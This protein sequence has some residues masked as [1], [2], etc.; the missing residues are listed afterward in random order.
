MYF[1]NVVWKFAKYISSLRF[2]ISLFLLLASVSVLGTIIEQDQTL[3]YYRLNYPDNK[4]FLFFV[5]WKTI[6]FSGLNHLYSTY[7]FCS[8]LFLFF[9]SLLLCTFS[10]QLPI[11][12]QARQWKFLYSKEFLAQKKLYSQSKSSSLMNFVYLL[13]F[14]YYYTFH[15]G[16][17]VYAYK[18]LLGRIAPI[19]VHMSIIITLVGSVLGA[20]G[21]FVVQEMIPNGEIFHVQNIVKAGYLSL[22]PPDF[23]GKV[24]DFFVTF[25]DDLSVQQFFS[26]ILLLDNNGRTLCDKSVS[27]NFP[28]RFNGLTFY[29]TDWQVNALRFQV[30]SDKY[31]VKSLQKVKIDNKITSFVWFCDLMLD[32]KHEIFIVV[33]DLSNSLLI[34]DHDR[35]LVT[36]TQY[37]VWN[38][39]YGVPIVFKDLMVSTGLQI[40][41]DPGL[42]ISY[43][44]FLILIVSIIVSYISYSQIWMSKQ[45]KILSLSGTTNRAFIFFEREFIRIYKKYTYLSGCGF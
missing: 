39:V 32:K 27:V 13:N 23:V 36:T 1:K 2:S 17:A 21:G 7:W 4:P 29:Q 5:T 42:Y 38:I 20:T 10:T 11:L 26:N 31:L 15:K 6:M 40:K 45:D 37:G 30:G 44:G 19:F 16:K 28:L 34:Y 24:N 41:M 33:P 14:N 12:K 3:D 25:N 8:I 43:L 9:L 18:G 22:L 35:F